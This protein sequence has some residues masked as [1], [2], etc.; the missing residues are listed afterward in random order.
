MKVFI[1]AD[2]EGIAGVGRWCA[3]RP[4]PTMRRR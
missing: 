3:T 2:I 1:S 4:T